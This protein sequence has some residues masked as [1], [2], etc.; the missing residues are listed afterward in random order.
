[1]E[2]KKNFKKATA[3]AEWSLYINLFNEVISIM[4]LTDANQTFIHSEKY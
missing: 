3:N 1:M 4:S 2:N